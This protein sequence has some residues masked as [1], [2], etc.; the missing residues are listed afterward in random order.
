MDS[1]GDVKS[2]DNVPS[3]GVEEYGGFNGN[4]YLVIGRDD[5]EEVKRRMCDSGWWGEPLDDEH[6]KE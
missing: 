5:P 2:F 1:D 3:T 4:C 6:A